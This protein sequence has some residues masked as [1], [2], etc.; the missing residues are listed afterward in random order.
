LIS[1]D[2]SRRVR[3]TPGQGDG[4]DAEERERVQPR[5]RA[6]PNR[7]HLPPGCLGL[8]HLGKRRLLPSQE[9]N[10]K[11]ATSQVSISFFYGQENSLGKNMKKALEVWIRGVKFVVPFS[12]QTML[13]FVF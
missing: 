13:F 3:S 11:I 9:A 12:Y 6:L 4:P 7:H 5:A 8:G 10:S 2:S 1:G